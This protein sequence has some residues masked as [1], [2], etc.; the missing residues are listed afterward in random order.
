MNGIINKPLLSICIPTYNRG[1][2]V[3]SVVKKILQNK[4]IDIEVYVQDNCS[5]DETE[6]LLSTIN[7]P[8]FV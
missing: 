7:D 6:L 2:H 3:F 8:R 1:N 4:S 5:V